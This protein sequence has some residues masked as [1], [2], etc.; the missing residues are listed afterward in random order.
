MSKA[1]YPLKLPRS[2]KDAA[3]RLSK[4]DGVSLNQW[5]ASAVAQK[6]GA[7]ETAEV[8]LKERAGAR[9]GSLLSAF[10]D[11]IKDAPALTALRWRRITPTRP[12][13]V[14]AA[15]LST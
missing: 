3:T 8:F 13:H 11:R 15:Q 12:G 6:I 14:R 10:L 5:I 2:I 4:A 1:S 7:V 9:D